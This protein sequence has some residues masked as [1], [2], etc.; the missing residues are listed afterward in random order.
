MVTK[1]QQ[2]RYEHNRRIYERFLDVLRAYRD[3]HISRAV[4]CDEVC[5][6]KSTAFTVHSLMRYQ[7][8]GMFADQ[9]DLLRD[10]CIFI[11]DNEQPAVFASA[12]T[13]Q[14]TGLRVG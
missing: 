7:V 12:C 2:A 4:L 9:H 10:F 6:G 8:A 14:L 13:A 5:G 11:P 1:I 3:G